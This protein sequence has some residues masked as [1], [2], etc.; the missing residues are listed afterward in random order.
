M[1]ILQTLQ[2]GTRPDGAIWLKW[3]LAN[4]AASVVSA[5]LMVEQLPIIEAMYTTASRNAIKI[6]SRAPGFQQPGLRHRGSREIQTRCPWTSDLAV[7]VCPV[8]FL[9]G[10]HLRA[11]A[12]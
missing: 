5:V 11:L 12:Q 3:V 6:V 8:G 4:A 1:E 10:L 2:L 9:A 7:P